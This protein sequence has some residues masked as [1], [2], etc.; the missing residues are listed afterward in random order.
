MGSKGGRP[1]KPKHRLPKVPKYEEPAEIPAAALGGGA[2][3]GLGRA[4]HGSDHHHGRH[5]GRAG[6]LLLRLL[7]KR[8]GDPASR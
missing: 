6:K 8:S 7:G 2:A 3:A 1:R 4:G 5:V